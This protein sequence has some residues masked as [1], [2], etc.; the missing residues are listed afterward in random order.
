MNNQPAV[1]SNLKWAGLVLV[2]MVGAASYFLFQPTEEARVR[3][4]IEKGRK[5]VEARSVL[6]LEPL[7]HPMYTDERGFD[8]SILLGQARQAFADMEE[9]GVRVD[10][11]SIELD[12]EQEAALVQ[13]EAAISG[14][15]AGEEWAGIA[16]EDGAPEAMTLH[17]EKYKGNWRMKSMEYLGNGTN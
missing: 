17:L 13:V 9:V 14:K 15:T 3:K 7:V 11:K 2:L 12:G 10:V 8:K 6:A 4:F 5:A 16:S 1:S